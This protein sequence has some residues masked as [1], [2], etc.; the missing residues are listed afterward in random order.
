ML[1]GATLSRVAS[2]V[3]TSLAGSTWLWN[4]M[5]AFVR[6]TKAQGES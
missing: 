2:E 3:A 1:R 6:G 4:P 5:Q